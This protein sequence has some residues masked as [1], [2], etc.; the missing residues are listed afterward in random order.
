MKAA[1]V[2]EC[3]ERS[4]NSDKNFEQKK[5]KLKEDKEKMLKEIAEME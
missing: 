2:S 5:N 1:R 4:E 3:E